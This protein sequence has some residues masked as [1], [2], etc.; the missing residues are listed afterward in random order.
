MNKTQYL[1]LVAKAAAAADAYYL[2]DDPIMS[3]YEYD[4]MIQ[5]IKRF[6][7][8]NP[9]DIS[10]DSP[11]QMVAR[12]VLKSSFEKVTHKVP[13]L[14]L[15]D[16]FNYADVEEFVKNNPGQAF[17]VE[18]KIDGLSMS[19]T[20]ENGRLVK[21]ETRGDGYIGEDITENAKYIKG[22]PKTITADGTLE[23]RC[24]VYL[25]ID[26]FEIL[27]KGK[28]RNG[29]KLFANPRNAAAGLLRTKNIDDM[30]DAGLECFVFNIQRAETT[31][32][33]LIANSHLHQLHA[34]A[35]LGFQVVHAR[36]CL[37]ITQVLRAIED[38]DKVDRPCLN[39][40]IDG[41]V[42]KLDSI[43]QRDALGATGKYPRWAVAFKYPPEE[44]ETVIRYITLQTGRTGRI[45]PVAVF[46]PVLLAGTKV[47]R[48]TLNNQ[49]FISEMGVNAGDT[50][51]VR[52]AAEIIPQIIRVV[53]KGPNGT[54]D[55]SKQVCECCGAPIT[56][57]N[58]GMTCEC[59]NPNCPYQFAKHVEFWAS[60]DCMDIRGM[61]PSVVDTLINYELIKSI[62]DIYTLE[63]VPEAL[64]E[65]FG[66][67]TAQNL[68]ASI[69]ASKNQD[70]DRLIKAFGIPGVGRHI[71]KELAKRYPDIFAIGE[72]PLE[73]GGYEKK[74]A[75]LAAIEGIGEISARAIVDYFKVHENWEMIFALR[76]R[77]VNT[78]SKQY[79][80]KPAGGNM[81]EGLTFVITG[82]LPR[83]S[84]EEAKAYIESLGGKVSGSVSKKTDYLVAGEAAGSKLTK[85]QEL[86]ITIID[87]D[88]LFALSVGEGKVD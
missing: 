87:E 29:E 61:G 68:L 53:K 11:T 19:A 2:N 43:V 26:R 65:I 37:D 58:D 52:K 79:N 33:G 27:N 51:L 41:A 46:E 22:L 16:V 49:R 57:E 24:E 85:A 31:N 10:P 75:E 67:K 7:K 78:S 18:H 47:E 74:V 59:R 82:T 69:E 83:M 60:R 76:S 35:S 39:Y 71:G 72:I 38:I 13:M 25:P 64:E 86:G 9:G 30:K 88:Q 17:S 23:V 63:D 4:A 28:M 1:E 55:M 3:D 32:E 54:Y 45:T 36:K 50:V 44:K 34:L 6:E 21:A 56:V 40:W 20:Y 73:A 80:S 48:A 70:I 66:K 8:E 12:S 5:D 81:F 42:V 77:G 15:M 84:R 62:D 14:S